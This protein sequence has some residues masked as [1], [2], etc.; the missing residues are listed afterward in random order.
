MASLKYLKHAVIVLH[1]FAVCGCASYPIAKSVKLV[2]FDSDPRPGSSIGTVKGESCGIRVLGT[3]T[4]PSYLDALT[5]LKSRNG[6]RYVNKLNVDRAYY[7][8]GVWDRTCWVISGEGF[9]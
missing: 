8:F 2:A 9:K 5:E 3:G 4:L 1:I 6:L 7:N